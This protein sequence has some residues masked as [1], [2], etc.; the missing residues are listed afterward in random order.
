MGRYDE[1]ERLAAQVW[2]ELRGQREHY[3]GVH[4]MMLAFAMV[5]AARGRFDEA[6]RL[7]QRSY[8]EHEVRGHKLHAAWTG[9]SVAYEM[10]RA[11][12]PQEARR[13]IESYLRILPDMLDEGWMPQLTLWQ[14]A[15]VLRALNERE[16]AQQLLVRSANIVATRVAALP[17]EEQQRRFLDFPSNREILRAHTENVWPTF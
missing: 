6:I 13:Y 4:H 7:M 1:A 16:R 8:D 15:Q 17:R 11:G 12:R 2:S 5:L 3:F 10:L 14:A 9:T